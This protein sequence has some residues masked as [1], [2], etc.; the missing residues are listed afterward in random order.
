MAGAMRIAVERFLPRDTKLPA[1]ADAVDICIRQRQ[2]WDV[3]AAPSA[4]GVMLVR[5][6]LSP[7]ACR[8][9]GSPLLDLGAT[10]A[11]DLSSKRVIAADPPEA[12]TPALVPAELPRQSL[13]RIEANEAAAIQLAMEELMPEGTLVADSPYEPACLSQLSSYDVTFVSEPEGVVLVRFDVND[14][15]CPPEGPPDIVE[16]KKYFGPT[17]IT[18]YAIDIRTMRILGID[19]TTRQRF[20]E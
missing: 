6:A 12:A 16:G 20:M 19:L 8:W 3:E 1:Q 9:G 13:R 17:F 7:G 11:V 5:I 4:D 10:Y 2:T 18:T 14:E 15:R